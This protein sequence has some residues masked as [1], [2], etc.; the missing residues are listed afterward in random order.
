[1]SKQIMGFDVGT[2]NLVFAKQEGKDII[3]ESMRN[4]FY[5]LDPE[6]LNT[7]LF[8]PDKSDYI[9]IKNDKNEIEKVILVGQDAYD[10]CNAVNAEVFRP[11]KKG[12]ISS[13]ELDSLDVISL[14]IEK[15][16]GG[17][18]TD[19]YCVYSIPAQPVDIDAPSVLWHE[20]VFDKIFTKLGYKTKAMNEGMSVIFAECSKENFTGIGISFGAGLTNVALSFN[21]I[22]VLTFAVSRGGDWIDE[23]VG[24]NQNI[25]PNK[26]SKVK[27]KEDFNVIDPSSG[28][29]KQEQR[30]RENIAVYYEN[31]INYV[32]KIFIREFQK[33][34]DGIDLDT[35]IT[36]VVSG[37]TSKAN[38]FLELFK[39][40]L[41]E[42]SKDFPFDIKEIRSASDPL[43]AVARG[44]LVYALWEESKNNPPKKGKEK[45]E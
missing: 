42:N 43:D 45:G 10:L 39:K 37:G 7:S 4:M 40:V 36:I 2:G 30:I 27:E 25:K 3:S 24:E 31:L 18:V 21:G 12:V 23:K 22:P 41:D 33:K 15:M 26:I 6:T 1:M 38:G 28:G 34:A 29:R 9:E 14:M 35:D 5:P 8:S 32:L 16:I 13:Q 19:G 17:K 20:K 44:N 11:M